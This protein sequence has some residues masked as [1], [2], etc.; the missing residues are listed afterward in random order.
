MGKVNMVP[1][2]VSPSTPTPAGS[3]G[4]LSPQF[5]NYADVSVNGDGSG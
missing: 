3:P 4:R 1:K 5:L 2:V